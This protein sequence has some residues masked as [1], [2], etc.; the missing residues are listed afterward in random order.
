MTFGAGSA[1][2][3]VNSPDAVAQAI[4]T[5][6]RLELGEWF[7]D[8]TEGTAYQTQVLGYGT[9]K[10]RDIEVRNRILGTQG[11]SDIAEYSSANDSHRNFSVRG[12]VNTLYGAANI[13]A[14]DAI[15]TVGRWN[16]FTWNG[17]ATW[18]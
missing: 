6:L 3:L 1:N 9:A 16:E 5:R 14:T 13:G 18:G 15:V 8:V 10:S 11:V 7:L 4:M 12:V 17:I 2:F